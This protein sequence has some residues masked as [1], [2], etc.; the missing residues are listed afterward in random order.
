MPAS[1]RPPGTV[2]AVLAAADRVGVQEAASS[3]FD[4]PQVEVV[5]R[6][7]PPRRQ[8]LWKRAQQQLQAEVRQTLAQHP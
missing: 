5:L 4:Q 6:E 3:L 2:I 1:R 8:R 7:F